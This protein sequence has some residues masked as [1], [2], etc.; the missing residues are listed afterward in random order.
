MSAQHTPGPWVVE[1]P[2]DDEL[3]IVEAGKHAY[4]WRT[5]AGCPLPSERGDISPAQVRANARLIAAAPELLAILERVN[6]EAECF[7]GVISSEMVDEIT[8]AIAKARGE[9]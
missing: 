7:L 9:A 3:W 4:E 2:M 6:G 5:I 1:A 8:A